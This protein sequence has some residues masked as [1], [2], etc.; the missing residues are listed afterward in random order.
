[1]ARV[2]D[3]EEKELLA[4]FI[5]EAMDSL[6]S[7]DSMFVALEHDPCEENIS[8]IFR[9]VHTIK[10]N[11]AYFEMEKLTELT[12]KLETLLDLCR[13]GKVSVNA[14][15]TSLLLA[16]MD[17][18]KAMLAR[19]HVG[20]GEVGDAESLAILVASVESACVQRTDAAAWVDLVGAITSLQEAAGGTSESKEAATTALEAVTQ[21][22][23]GAE[24][25]AKT[26]A[27]LDPALAKA[28]TPDKLVEPKEPPA[29]KQVEHS[30]WDNPGR[31]EADVAKRRTMRVP[32]ESINSF[33]SL[34]GELV[35]LGEMFGH[36]QDRISQVSGGDDVAVELG[37]VT[38]SFEATSSALQ[39]GIMSVRLVPIRASLQK[40]PRI[41]RD[42]ANKRR[43][44]IEVEVIGEEIEVDKSHLGVLEGPI[45][46]MV[47]NAADHGIEMPDDRERAGKSRV[48]HITIAVTS[49]EEMLFLTVSDDGGGLDLDSLRDKARS[50]GLINADQPLNHDAT[51][52]LLFSSGVSTAKEVTDVSGRGVGMD[53]VR[54]DVENAGGRISVKTEPGKGSTFTIQLPRSVSTQIIEAFVVEVGGSFCVIPIEQVSESFAIEP[55][56]LLRL[57]SGRYCVKRYDVVMGIVDLFEVFKI[58]PVPEIEEGILVAIEGEEKPFAIRVNRII[59]TQQVVVKGLEMMDIS[60]NV[61]SGCAVMGDGEIALVL[62]AATLLTA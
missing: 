61:F 21:L 37:R 62:D 19:M 57:T 36:V 14:E 40:A 10:G 56:A 34:V 4:E 59:G 43:K 1:V 31:R 6:D 29:G 7:L 20:D 38:E 23:G 48:G 39:K 54:R 15:I 18:L 51:V 41:V 45:T 33:L 49:T 55:G 60:P 25:A 11:A 53:A 50:L 16:G 5:D 47:R 2:F 3:D 17:E 58:S 46:H 28:Q 27:S 42:I 22:V 9:P 13:K 35:V 8:A 12:H 44:E 26:R 30:P 32:E 52:K 24:V